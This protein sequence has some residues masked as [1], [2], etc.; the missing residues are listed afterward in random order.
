MRRVLQEDQE[1]RQ[2]LKLDEDLDWAEEKHHGLG[3][4]AGGAAYPTAITADTAIP[5]TN[6]GY[7]LL[8]KMGWTVG[9]GL[10]RNEDGACGRGCSWADAVRPCT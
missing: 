2:R 10:G 7:Q 4:E 9:K 5:E 6:V 3:D 8:L 1:R